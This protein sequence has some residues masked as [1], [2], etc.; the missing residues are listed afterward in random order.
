MK[1]SWDQ[2]YSEPGFAYGRDPNG[3]FRQVLDGLQPGKILLPGEGE[4][5]NAIYAARKQWDVTAFDQSSV[6][7]DKA[8][9]WAGSE[10]LKINYLL[11][12]MADFSCDKPDF[13]LVAIIYVHFPPSIRQQIHRKLAECL[14]P[15]GKF[16]IECFHKTQLKY[17]TGGPPVEELLYLEDDLKEDFS[18]LKIIRC[19]NSIVYKKEGKYHAGESSIIRFI[20]NNQN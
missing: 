17:G 14:K 4:G 7:R 13:D 16:I 2:R 8:M 19:E 11:A 20:A 9:G 6:A 12:D 18:E 10:K 1:N 15:G 3:F 5:R